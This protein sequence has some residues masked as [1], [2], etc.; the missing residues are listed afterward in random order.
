MAGYYKYS[1]SNNAIAAYE[2]GE[3]PK[4]RWKKSEIIEAIAQ[5]ISSGEVKECDLSYI[6]KIPA[7]ELK[8]LCLRKTSYHHTSSYYNKT[9][10]YSVD[11]D[12]VSNLSKDMIESYKI[13]DIQPDPEEKW[14]CRFLEWSG[15]RRHPK[16][17]EIEEE[18]VI[19]GDWFYRK[20]GEKKSINANGFKKVRRCDV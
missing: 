18:G 4:S 2:D 13:L 6:K 5:A 12:R 7:K 3:K 9:D 20:S 8:D 11:Y 1:M 10:F 16:A 17:T 15:T 14:I 19:K